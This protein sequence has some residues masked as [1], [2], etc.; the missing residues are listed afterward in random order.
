MNSSE[1]FF[2]GFGVDGMRNVWNK[3]FG[4]RILV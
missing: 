1:V 2:K 4:G 3:F